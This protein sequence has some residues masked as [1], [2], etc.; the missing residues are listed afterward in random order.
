MRRL[1]YRHEYFV[2]KS[3]LAASASRSACFLLSQLRGLQAILESTVAFAMAD[4]DTF[5]DDRKLVTARIRGLLK[6]AD[7]ET[8]RA[9]EET[10]RQ[11]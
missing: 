3:N 8:L 2:S 5:L 9:V 4:H 7:L 6:S 1:T 11:A 10:L